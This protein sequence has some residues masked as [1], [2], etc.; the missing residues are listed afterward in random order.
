[1]YDDQPLAPAHSCHTGLF[2]A[3]PGCS[4]LFPACS[5]LF[6][7]VPGCSRPVPGLFPA[8]PGCSRLFPAVPGCSRLFPACSRLFPAVPGCSRL[9]PA[10]SRLFPACSRLFPA[11]SRLFPAC[12]RLFPACSRLSPLSFPSSSCCCRHILSALLV[13]SVFVCMFPQRQ[14]IP[15]V[16]VYYWP[17][18]VTAPPEAERTFEY[19]SGLD[20]PGWMQETIGFR[21]SHMGGVKQKHCSRFPSPSGG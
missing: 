6:P 20:S 7:A 19:S 21:V 4:R 8:V 15:V 16:G 12:S 5:R 2:P 3:V 18:L 13:P 1:L 10:C 9:F 17:R 14:R 11:C